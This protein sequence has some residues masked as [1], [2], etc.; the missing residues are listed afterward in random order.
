VKNGILSRQAKGVINSTLARQLSRICDE[1]DVGVFYPVIYRV[2]I[3]KIP[4]DRLVKAGSGITGSLEYLVPDLE[5]LEIDDILFLD[6]DRDPLIKRL[7]RVEFQHYRDYQV[8]KTPK[9][10]VL[11][12]LEARITENAS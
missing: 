7:V 11:S 3:G 6:Y 12:L 10:E 4:R 9:A 8:T 5:E 2:D 1:I